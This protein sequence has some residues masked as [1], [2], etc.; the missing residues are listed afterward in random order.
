MF[1]LSTRGT[2]VNKVNQE[3]RNFKQPEFNSEYEKQQQHEIKH[4]K[5]SRFSAAKSQQRCLLHW[6]EFCRQRTEVVAK[7]YSD[8]L[9]RKG[10]DGFIWNV[11]RA[12]QERLLVK[13]QLEGW[14]QKHCFQMWHKCLQEKKSQVCKRNR[15]VLE[16][17]QRRI[18]KVCWTVWHWA[19]WFISKN[20]VA[21]THYRVACLRVSLQT[22]RQCFQVRQNMT[23]ITES[24][25][26]TLEYRLMSSMF[27]AMRKT[28]VKSKLATFNFRHV[29]LV[30]VFG[31][32]HQWSLLSK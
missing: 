17:S 18:C 22:W 26:V 30:K 25:S 23:L 5:A 29:A 27:H 12:R 3:R 15:I 7:L 28:L 21:D 13:Q 31:R 10:L 19:Y 14:R 1:S 16:Q 24:I 6:V 32:W 4:L 20:K 8:H 9:K 2:L 11:Q